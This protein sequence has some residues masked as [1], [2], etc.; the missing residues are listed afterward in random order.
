MEYVFIHK[1]LF[2]K[3]LFIV[4]LLFVEIMEKFVNQK[5]H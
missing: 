1:D 2:E 3:V 4:T 5:L